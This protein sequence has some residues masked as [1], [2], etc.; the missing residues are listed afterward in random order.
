MILLAI[1]QDTV[2]CIS[3]Y[4]HRQE[5]KTKSKGE[6][7]DC[8]EHIYGEARQGRATNSSNSER[9]QKDNKK[10][11]EGEGREEEDT[12]KSGNSGALFL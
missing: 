4:K 1:G 5:H 3:K 11:S 7:V 9:E 10:K 6:K 2:G 12:E 8:R